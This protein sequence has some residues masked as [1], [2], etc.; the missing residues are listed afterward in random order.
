MRQLLCTATLLLCLANPQAGMGAE[1]PTPPEDIAVSYDQEAQVARVTVPV[2]EGRMQWGEFLRGLARARGFDDKAF[3]GMWSERTVRVTGTGGRVLLGIIDRVFGPG[4]EIQISV[5]EDT[6]NGLAE[7][8]LD[9]RGLL[10]TEIRFKQRVKQGLRLVR[11]DRHRY[12]LAFDDDWSDTP[13]EKNLVVL[14]HGLQSDS[15]HI[16]GI[17]EDVRQLEHPCATFDYPNDQP[18]SESAR[19]LAEELATVAEEHPE[20]KLTLI[21]HS[22]GGLVA[23]AVIENEQLNPGNVEQLIMVAPPNHGSLLAHLAF[24]FDFWEYLGDRDKKVA[25]R[26]FAA[27]EDGLGEAPDDLRPKSLFLSQL[28]SQPRN[29]NVTYSILLGTD[30]PL[31][32]ESLEGLRRSLRKAGDRS[33]L[34]RFLGDRLDRYLA[35]LEEVVRGKGDG[36]VAVKR[37]KLRGVPDIEVLDF[38]HLDFSRPPNSPGAALIREAV[39]RRL[40]R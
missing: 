25:E 11:P 36:A 7:I 29:P 8:T 22:M 9:R 30:A 18:I 32:E 24:G 15:G 12:S 5:D 13:P 31:S 26:F 40:A 6:G 2:R 4:V 21:T 20:R 3:D 38:D 17:L 1:A 35:D 23:R 33:R 16:G 39:L 19:L 37:G 28:N 34:V 27:L 10:A 14:I